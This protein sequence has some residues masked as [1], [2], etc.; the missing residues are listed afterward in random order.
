MRDFFLADTSKVSGSS[1]SITGLT[2]CEPSSSLF[3]ASL[4]NLWKNELDVSNS[5]NWVSF[6]VATRINLIAGYLPSAT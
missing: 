5:L 3:C 2:M 6:L 4:V 1:D